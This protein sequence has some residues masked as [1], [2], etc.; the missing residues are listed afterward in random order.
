MLRPL[1]ARFTEQFPEIALDI[2][3]QSALIDIVAGRYD[4]GI[5]PSSRLAKDMIA[6]R[7]TDTIRSAIV[8]AP[9]LFGAARAAR[10]R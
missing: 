9:A 10:T 2:S 3:A 7:I 8:A 6:L 5:R 4:A 1:L